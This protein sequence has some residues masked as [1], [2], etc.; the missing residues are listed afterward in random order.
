MMKRKVGNEDW[1]V[2][3]DKVRK[4][5]VSDLSTFLGC[6]AD[7]PCSLLQRSSAQIKLV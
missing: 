7:I 6:M 2:E 4:L 1:K 5:E 3:I